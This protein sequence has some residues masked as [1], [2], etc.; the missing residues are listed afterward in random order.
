MLIIKAQKGAEFVWV[1]EC[2]KSEGCEIINQFVFLY[3]VINAVSR[4]LT[5]VNWLLD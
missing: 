1:S 5:L 4:I 3:S 2:Q